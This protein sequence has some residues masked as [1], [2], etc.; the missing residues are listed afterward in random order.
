MEMMTGEISSPFGKRA[1]TVT[2]DWLKSFLGTTKSTKEFFEKERRE[3]F[4]T[5]STK[6]IQGVFNVTSD[7]A[8]V[9]FSLPSKKSLKFE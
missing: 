5:I 2:D 1:V 9:G 4:K 8:V 6:R 3:F 7:N